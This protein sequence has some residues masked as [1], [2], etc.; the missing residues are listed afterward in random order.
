MKNKTSLSLFML[1]FSIL[2]SV[3]SCKKKPDDT[4]ITESVKVK[5][6]NIQGVNVSVK[7]GVVTLSG[8]VETP[9]LSTQAEEAAKTADGVKSVV[10]TLT[11][12]AP[13]APVEP[14][15]T[16]S[17]DDSLK[18]A[19]DDKFKQYN[20]SGVTA[21]V[22]DGEVTLEGNVKRAQLQEVIKAANE[23]KPKKVNNKL[24]ISK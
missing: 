8:E 10:N 20:I 3:S 13:P 5:T 23:A 9:E 1:M 6:Q 17:P 22:K 7:E 4:A 16:F 15:R 11:V 19:V 12:K 14:E 2:L 18:T 24:T 21:S